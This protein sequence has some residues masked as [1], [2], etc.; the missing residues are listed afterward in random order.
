VQ[1]NRTVNGS[2]TFLAESAESAKLVLCGTPRRWLLSTP[3]L[4]YPTP[5]NKYSNLINHNIST[6]PFTTLPI[7][8]PDINV[9]FLTFCMQ[10]T[11]MVEEQQKQEI[12]H[13]LQELHSSR[14]CSC[15]CCSTP[16]HYRCS[17]IWIQS[18]YCSSQACE[19][20]KIS[21]SRRL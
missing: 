11:V 4:F 18:S 3:F 5:I 19:R 9:A 12:I 15:S 1:T 17:C 6:V 10:A 14:S 13:S 20:G 16:I 2:L 8:Y 21:H 7:T